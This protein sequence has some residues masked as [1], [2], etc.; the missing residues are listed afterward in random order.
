MAIAEDIQTEQEA[1]AVATKAP[2]RRGRPRKTAAPATTVAEGAES[3]GARDHEAEQAPLAGSSAAPDQAAVVEPLAASSAPS[4]PN[5]QSEGGIDTVTE[6][7]AL[8]RSGERDEASAVVAEPAAVDSESISSPASSDGSEPEGR[9]AR[10]LRNDRNDRDG[11]NDRQ[12]Q[13]NNRNNRQG[14][15]GRG[16]R[17]DQNGQDVAGDQQQQ[18]RRA[19]NNQRDNRDQVPAS[20]RLTVAELDS[21]EVDALNELAKELGVSGYLRMRKADLITR[22]LQAQTER[23]GH[24]F[25][26]GVLE[27]I[28]DGFG[29]LRGQRFL[30]GPDDIYVSQSQIR[31]FGLRTGD[32][33]SG[34]VRPP[35]DNEKFF[36]LLRVEAVN[37]IDPEIARR[38]P[39]FDTLTPIFPL[40]RI[41]LET[42]HNILSTRLLDLVAPIGRGQRGLIVSPP[43][44]GKTLLLKAIAN[45]ITSNNPDMHLMVCLIGERPEEVTDMR[46]TVEGEVISSTFDEPV[47]DHTKVA[48]MALER[49]KR[50]VESGRDVTILLDSITRLARAYNL[51]VPPSGRT[52]SGGIDPVALYPPKRFFGAARNIEG[53]G[54]LT[55]ISTCLIDTGSRQDDVIYEEFKGTG[56]MELHLDRKLAERRI[57]PAI[58]I[59]RSG[60]RREELLL[61]DFTLRQVW[62]MRRMV[63][64][65]GGSEGTELLLSRLAKTQKNEEFLETLTKDV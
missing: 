7:P 37:G 2:A 32:R 10:P 29:F 20:D 42:Q 1:G 64:M 16:P 63:S 24:T 8:A 26:D 9:L 39:S 28:E 62:T 43:K 18:G 36:S 4:A 21:R 57:Y 6:G 41:N 48:E 59:Q 3:N 31:R 45:G 15:N 65:L 46:R 38:R 27:I 35:K 60:T 55:I 52:L 56:N 11:R 12:G 50:L 34:Q 30:P 58:D 14:K 25:G 61:D 23:D 22:L 51:A 44:A 19:G 5:A 47:E 13:A 53:G 17:N 49:A 33:V 54:S 40:E